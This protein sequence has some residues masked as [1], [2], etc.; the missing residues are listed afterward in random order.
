MINK[1]FISILSI[2]FYVTNDPLQDMKLHLHR[3]IELY[4]IPPQE[5]YQKDT[6]Y[7][8]VELLKLDIN[9]YAEVTA[10]NLS[11]AAPGWLKDNIVKQQQTKR[12]DYKKLHELAVKGKFR[13]CSIVF[14]III[15]SDDF[16]GSSKIKKH[17][18]FNDYSFRFKGKELKGHLVFGAP[19]RISWPHLQAQ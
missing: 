8:F 3:S 16:A 2:G 4:M 6:S 1:L 13:S 5:F 18:E 14:P 15:E 9:K 19:I 17:S 7:Q 10:I 12:I 11:D